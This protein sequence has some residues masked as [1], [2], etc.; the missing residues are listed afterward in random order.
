MG[1]PTVTAA[2]EVK[3]PETVV[4]VIFAEPDATAVTNPLA[5][6]VATAVLL[7]DHVTF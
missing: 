3:L 7:D 2:D 1:I 4:A 6:T 5:S